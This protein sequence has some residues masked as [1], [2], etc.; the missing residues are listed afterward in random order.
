MIFIDTLINLVVLFNALLLSGHLTVCIVT[1]EWI[2]LQMLR[3][4]LI[5]SSDNSTHVYEINSLCEFLKVNV[6]SE[7]F[8]HKGGKIS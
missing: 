7:E 4:S 8:C 2:S 6:T 5:C 1:Q 3:L